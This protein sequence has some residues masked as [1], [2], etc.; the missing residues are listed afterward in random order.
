MFGGLG[1]AM[2]EPWSRIE[3][4]YLSSAMTKRTRFYS[5]ADRSVLGTIRC[6]V[7]FVMAFWSGPARLAFQEL[8]RVLEAVD[9]EGRLELVVVDTDGCP[10]IYQLPEFI[11][12][13]HGAGEAAWIR[14]GRVI[15]TSGLGYR[16]ACYEPNTR[17]L[18]E[19][20]QLTLTG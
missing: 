18:L 8:K 7:L 5:E 11:G 19:E 13:M 17:L 12:K 20:C 3:H 14:D 9:P 2:G 15:C 6:G 16:P 1:V 4:L 10:D